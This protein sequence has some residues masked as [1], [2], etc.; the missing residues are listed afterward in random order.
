M[1]SSRDGFAMIGLLMVT[2][3]MGCSGEKAVEKPITPVQVSTVQMYSTSGAVRYSASV[4][5]DEPVS[6]AFKNGGYVVAIHQVRDVS[7][8]MRNVQAGDWVPAG[9]VLARVREDDYEA[10]VN[11]AKSQLAEAR[12]ALSATEFQLV[13][14]KATLLKAREDYERAKN[15]FN[16]QS[17]TK[18]DF[19]Q[20]QTKLDNSQSQVDALQSQVEASRSKVGLAQAQLDQANISFGDCS[21]KAPRKGQVLQRNIE[22]GNMASRG[23]SVSSCPIP[24]W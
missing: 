21:L 10:V 12:S 19:E 2:L 7:G 24:R 15:L 8:R 11:Q 23:W 5:A 16:S 22:L 4:V 14:A 13:G 17:Y 20:A 9:T 6:L 18:S 1:K 3:L